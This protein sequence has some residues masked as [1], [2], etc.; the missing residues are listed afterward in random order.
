M[1]EAT[2]KL[3][4]GREVVITGP[5]NE[6]IMQRAAAL[7]K[8]MAG[9]DSPYQLPN[10]AQQ[11]PGA[12]LN[13]PTFGQRMET[14]Q[15]GMGAR[16]SP[17]QLAAAESGVDIRSGA[18]VGRFS[19]GFSQNKALRAEDLRKRLSA[20]FGQPIEVRLGPYS[21]EIEF[22]DPKTGRFTL[23]DEARLTGRDIAEM[24]GPAIPAA[25]GIA[26]EFLG[27]PPGAAIGGFLGEAARR[28]IGYVMGVREETSQ[29]AGLG[30]LGAGA[31]EGGGSLAARGVERGARL[32]RDFIKPRLFSG[33]EARSL[34]SRAEANQAVSDSISTATGQEFKPFTG[35][36]TEDPLLLAEE[37]RM[38][39]SE[40][41]GAASRDRLKQN[42]TALE[43]YFYA[44]TPTGDVPPSQAGREI[45]A[46]ARSQTAPRVEVIEE[47]VN[48]QL[49]E[50]EKLTSLIPRTTDEAAG[51][52]L[53]SIIAARREEAKQG[54]DLLWD[55]VRTQYGYDPNTSL[56]AFKVPVN[57]Q[58][59][60]LLNRFKV[61]AQQAIDP[62]TATGKRTLLPPKLAGGEETALEK[63]INELL[64]TLGDEATAGRSVDL[65]QLQ[66]LL[67]SIRRRERLAYTNVSAADPEMRD[68]SSLRNS[69][70]VQR[71]EYLKKN[72]PELL[73]TIEQAE[74]ARANL[75]RTFDS[76]SVGRILKQTH[77]EYVIG[78][79]DV[80]GKAIASGDPEA[81]RHLVSVV[82]RHPAG[83]A[84]LQD[85][86]LSFYRQEAVEGGLPRS[87]LHARFVRKYGDAL[88]ILF[89]G[90]G[91][92]VRRLGEME[93][94]VSNNL[95]R[96]ED[97]RSRVNKSFRGRIQD[98][99]PERLVEDVFN[100]SFS[101]REAARLMSLA[102]QSGYGDMYQQAVGSMIARKYISLT[103]GIKGEALNNFVGANLGKLY[104]VFGEQ[105]VK[106][107]RTLVRGLEIARSK[108]TSLSDA[109]RFSLIEGIAR[110]TV[111]RPLSASGVGLTRAMKF[112]QQAADRLMTDVLMNPKKLNEFVR[113]ASTDIRNQRVAGLLGASGAS[114]LAIQEQ[115]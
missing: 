48:R 31:I 21:Q 9:G 59:Q 53:R 78:D 1:P 106:D 66:V 101:E 76:G 33:Q 68:L 109:G 27:G 8:E 56:S 92:V 62:A 4:D 63:E 58:L 114:S 28:G 102:R 50:L 71:N 12:G 6:A 32:V 100:R 22:K 2:L 17:Q 65:H 111:A 43:A 15:R 3:L 99:A 113:L 107:M 57:G 82:G 77:G 60:T 11:Y 90:Q 74:A 10:F 46:E 64:V 85:S 93:G 23:A 96:F 89:P 95:K 39:R 13:T 108:S 52:R 35:Q 55:S 41:A 25:S 86:M 42:E 40:E 34:M 98:L 79:A 67:H 84:T 18:P 24:A 38:L 47:G 75:S 94:V 16:Y 36:L 37:G 49:S 88:D 83:L 104:A 70:V 20:H 91:N 105:Y 115:E 7:R 97:F 14:S 110:T 80:V 81:M 30:A 45:Q 29:E 61:E 69:L 26:G 72:N 5:N 51:A 87:Q 44:R 103:G 112:R 19:A 54:V 73:A